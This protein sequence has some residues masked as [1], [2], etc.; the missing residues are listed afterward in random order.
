MIQ[1]P[2]NIP[3]YDPINKKLKIAIILGNYYPNVAKK[4]EEACRNF[5]IASGVKEENITVFTVPG[6]WE[7]PLA[8]K[9]IALSKKF[10]GIITLA[11]IVKGQTYHFELV[12]NECA[13]ALMNISLEFNVPITFEVLAVYK[14]E[15]AIKRIPGRGIDAGKAFLKNIK[16]LSTI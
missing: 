12:S 9:K 2:E 7:I 1:K 4:L 8:A 6:S 15:H 3:F 5:L 11:I 10:D 16:V 14:L 13:R